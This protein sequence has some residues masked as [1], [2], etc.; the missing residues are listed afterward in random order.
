MERRVENGAWVWEPTYR[1]NDHLG[2]TQAAT[3][4]AGL[5]AFQEY[6]TPYG[7]VENAR[8]LGADRVGFTGHIRDAATGLTYMQAR[9]YSPIAG[10]MLS[11]DPVDFMGS[12][13]D[14][15]YVN[16]YAYAG[17]D[18]ISNID[19]NGETIG[20]I[21]KLG[22]NIEKHDGNVF[23]GVAETG[24]GIVDDLSTLLDGKLDANDVSAVV[25]LVTGLDSKDQ[26]AFTGAVGRAVKALPGHKVS[27]SNKGRGVR[28]SN[29]SKPGDQVRIETGNKNSPNPA[30]Q[31]P[32]VKETRDGK[33]RDA[34][35][36]VVA[37]SDASAP[38]AHIPADEYR[39]R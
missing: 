28:L 39:P 18:P 20:K 8:P 4:R 33:V 5:A 14:P 23:K 2:G 6:Y 32:Y 1:H 22:R 7:E 34:N 15:R 3:D 16:R 27:V 25:S 11:V 31:G 12:G 35:G 24:A 38:E 21:V 19:P 30:Q 29:P 26:K 10:R 37:R 9:Y 13:Y 17:N 36:G